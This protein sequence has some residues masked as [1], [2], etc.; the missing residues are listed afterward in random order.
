MTPFTVTIAD[1]IAR[2]VLDLPGESVNKITRGVRDE[3]DAIL[4]S[5]GA[6]A[7]V[8]GVVLLSG[9][10]DTF[11]A[12]ADI[13]EFV[14]LPSREAAHTLVRT[15]QALINRIPSLGKPVVAAIH[16]ACLGGGLEA[17]LA[18]T[19]RVATEHEKTK[20]GLPEVQL[21][22]IPAAGGCQ[23][24]PRLIG[25][26]AALDIIL[27]GKVLP[28]RVAYRRGIVDDLVHPAI[29]E[30]VAV[31]VA[32][33]LADGWRPTRPTGGL[34]GWLLEGN[35]A[36]RALVFSLARKQVLAKTGGHYPAPLAALD[37][38]AEGLRHGIPA[39]LEREAR[40]FADLAV[41]DVSRALVG[42]FFATTALKK[43]FGGAEGVE[44][45][46]VQRLGILGAG[47]M[48]SGIGGTAATQ[49]GVDVRFRDT[50]L[51]AVG[52]G[53]AGAR[54]ILD[55]RL[56]RR[57]LTKFEHRRLTALLS[58]GTNWAGFGRTDLVIEAVFEDLEVKHQVFRELEGHVRD[59]CILASNTS[60]IPITRIAS[61]LRRPERILGM[62][63]FSPVE[64]MPLLEVITTAQT[65]SWVTATAVDFG[66]RMG[67][68]VV[69]VR[70][71]PGF[72]V[73][74]ILAPYLNEAGR[75]VAEGADVREIDRRMKQYGFP[76]G[77]ITL[78]DEVG[79]DVGLKA[80]RVLHEA[81]GERMAPVAGLQA[82]VEAGRL[83]RKTGRGFYRYDGG[84]RRGIDESVRDIVGAG[85]GPTPADV[86]DR[87][88]YAMLNEAALAME[89]GVVRT[90]RDGDIAAIFG[91][92]FPPF[93]GGPLRE[94]DRVGAVRA[95]E[96]L[97]RLETKY[98]PRF[99]PAP[100]LV[101][102]AEQGIHFYLKT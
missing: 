77:P 85:S 101:Q 33:R 12:G 66:R 61:V 35:P 37:A 52:K 56:K 59:E 31:D 57:R 58:G 8:R 11:I 63:F 23:R 70:D 40:H 99:A 46:S 22:I 86:E 93:R 50:G 64:K 29:L 39:G 91:I 25:L 88:V 19:Y 67:K 65:A 18:C 32:R 45:R 78:L 80:S 74:R 82:L 62:H 36:G 20:L 26:Q 4:T 71:E 84:R 83:G 38:V 48:G 41:G 42:I 69:V 53:I 49:T 72:W 5:L 102:Q 21:G 60:T 51:A 30:R 95:V 16:G 17:A 15:G 6:D 54:H 89:A 81:F 13:D 75:L 76:V 28:A 92:G 10:E 34:K 1:G 100:A 98:G 24:L 73:N 96:V 55:A 2:V 68:T 94:L 47:F 14:A 9:K 7:T 79:L 3:L 27:A 43:D 44:P 87:L 97:R 90:P